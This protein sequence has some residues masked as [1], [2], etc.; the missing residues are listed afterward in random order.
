MSVHTLI[1]YYNFE[2]MN[3]RNIFKA[4]SI[5][6]TDG[7]NIQLLKMYYTDSL[8]YIQ[9]ILYCVQSIHDLK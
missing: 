2:S 1:Y 3:S 7:K 8:G 6:D 4:Y 5:P 9:N